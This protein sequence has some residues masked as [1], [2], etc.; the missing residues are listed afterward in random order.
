[1]S[2]ETLLSTVNTRAMEARI[3]RA[4]RQRF[5]RQR[6]TLCFEHGQWWLFVSD[7]RTFSVVDAEGPGSIDGFDFEEV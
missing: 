3:A 1:M 2:D 5:P 6:R 7:D 4:A